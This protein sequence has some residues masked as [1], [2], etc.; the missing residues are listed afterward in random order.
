MLLES[1]EFIFTPTSALAKK[2][3]F[4]HQSIALKHRYERCKKKWL[5]HLKN[6][7]DLFLEELK[8]VSDKNS[9]VVLGSAHLHEIPLHLLMNNFQKV[10]LVDLVHPW[11]HHRLAKNNP[12]LQLID[13]DVSGAIEFLQEVQTFSDLQELVQKI[14]S[15]EL[16][17]FKADLIIS[18]NLLSQL[19]LLPLNQIERKTKTTL[20]HEQK[21]EICSAFGQMH[22][23]NLRKCQGHVL[24]YADREIFYRD[25]KQEL[26]YQ[27]HYDID[28]T[29]FSKIKEW[30]WLLS[31]LGEA[32]R[33]YS[34]EMKIEAW[35]G[36]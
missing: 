13:L 35:R 5:P 21:D 16:F 7:Q 24:L 34:V 28:F 19:A 14:G 30:S 3:G 22:L 33:K 18:G 4:L 26:I 36:L 31:P 25:R 12:R 15:Q 11:K 20:T 10:V 1:L 27:G 32:S 23:Q 9:V 17:N 2:Y 8:Y 6:C 29:G